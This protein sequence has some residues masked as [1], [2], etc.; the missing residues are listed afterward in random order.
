VSGARAEADDAQVLILRSALGAPRPA[1]TGAPSVFQQRV[2]RAA[3]G[4]PDPASL[5]RV[6][7]RPEDFPASSA[8]RSAWAAVF[9]DLVPGGD[10]VV[11]T[12]EQATAFTTWARQHGHTGRLVTRRRNGLQKVVWRVAAGK[13][14]A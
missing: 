13:D 14:S 2:P 3:V 8:P 11:L 12:N 7:Q 1:T 9:D 10:G 6:S 4:A 5:E